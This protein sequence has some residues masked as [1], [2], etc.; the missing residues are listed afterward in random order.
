MGRKESRSKFLSL[1]LRHKPET[2]G[3]TLDSNGW[4]NTDE[5][6]RNISINDKDFN[7][8][9]LEDIVRT[10]N[11]MRYSFNE[12]KTK[13]RANQGHS[14]T[15]DVELEIATPPD[16]LF[17]G[18]HH[19]ALLSI[20]QHGLK[21]MDRMHV[22]LSDNYATAIR[23]ASRRND[24]VVLRIDAT[25]MVEDGYKFYI[26]KNRVWLIESV[27]VKYIIPTKSI[28]KGKWGTP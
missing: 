21:K 4:A 23:V 6:I 15:V 19:A 10:D 17:H 9:V 22:H 8:K 16:I 1:V 12:D 24:P 18:T 5:L 13:I 3:I 2:I 7:M 14:L 20:S 25:K 11:K 27:P 26:S 28:F